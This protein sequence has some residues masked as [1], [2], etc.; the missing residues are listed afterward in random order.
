MRRRQ[1]A[2]RPSCAACAAGTYAAVKGSDACS[3]C[4]AGSYGDVTAMTAPKKCAGSFSSAKAV[5]ES[6]INTYVPPK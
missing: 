2:R 1:A 6:T 5:K 3:K 4:P